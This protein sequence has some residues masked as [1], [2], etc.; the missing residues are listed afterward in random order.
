MTVEALAK[1]LSLTALCLPE[2]DRTV[3]GCYCGDLLSWVMGRAKS[4][5]A[6][7]TIMTNINVVAVASLTD[8]ACVILAEDA[9]VEPQV[10]EKAQVQGINLLVSQKDSFALCAEIG[11]LLS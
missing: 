9:Q 10:L 8:C 3:E 1:Q 2:A 5:D 11:A 6:W 7:V 4:G